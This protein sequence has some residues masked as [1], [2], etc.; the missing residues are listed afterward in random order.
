M[1]TDVV[2]YPTLQLTVSRKA[3][4]VNISVITASTNPV[5]NLP[6]IGALAGECSLRLGSNLDSQDKMEDRERAMLRLV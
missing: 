5:T 2:F 6:E 3:V 1:R 4:S